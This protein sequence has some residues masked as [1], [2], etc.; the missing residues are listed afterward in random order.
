MKMTI[1]MKLKMISFQMFYIDKRKMLFSDNGYFV[2]K[3]KAVKI[4]KEVK[5][6]DV[7]VGSGD[8]IAI[9]SS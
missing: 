4:A 3:S 8:D 1:K 2:M 9:F 7:S 6:S 5:R